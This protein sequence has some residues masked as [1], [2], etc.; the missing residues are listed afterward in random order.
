MAKKSR[1]DEML[2]VALDRIG[3][4]LTDADGSNRKRLTNG[5]IDLFPDW[6]SK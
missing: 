1:R 3:V 6:Q 5:W 2:R 4:Y